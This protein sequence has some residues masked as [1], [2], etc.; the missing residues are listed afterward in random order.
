MVPNRLAPPE[1]IDLVSADEVERLISS[2]D[3]EL[4]ALDREA[5]AALAAADEAEAWMRSAQ[6]DEQ[7]STWAM[8]RLQRFLAALREEAERDSETVVE[9]AQRRAAFQ[10]AEA[11]A[12]AARIRER[13]AG[14][15]GSGW[16]EPVLEPGPSQNG[17]HADPA[18]P[19]EQ[20]TAEP[21]VPVVVPEAVDRRATDPVVPMAPPVKS[22]SVADNPGIVDPMTE[23]AAPTADPLAPAAAAAAT[24]RWEAR[25]PVPP[26]PAGDAVLV[27]PATAPLP[28]PPSTPVEARLVTTNEPEAPPAADSGSV[29]G[30]G[31]FW[32][33]PE[34]APAR[35]RGRRAG[36]TSPSQPSP[37]Q[38]SP[39]QPSP[40]AKTKHR[41]RFRLPVSAILEVI[42]VL[43]I[44]V[45]VLLRLS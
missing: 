27:T 42:A 44:L 30:D 13:R 19:A 16:S 35:R 17:K 31:E 39:S 3:E 11:R 26:P 7:S 25:E 32:T 12:E 14:G 6:V 24:I 33:E 1:P 8:V 41:R 36:K 34:A 43:L 4:A 2:T 40:P 29:S 45:F 5:V 28:P 38:D 9:L 10:L 22:P 20:Y 15:I 21:A 37:S 23:G 18:A